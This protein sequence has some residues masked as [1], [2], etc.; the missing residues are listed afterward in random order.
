VDLLPTAHAIKAAGVSRAT[1]Q[2]WLKEGRVKNA[3]KLFLGKDGRAVR[4]WSRAQ[5]AELKG[6]RQK[7]PKVP[8]K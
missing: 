4:L 7:A 5:I 8:K 2:R 1:L 6:L 3:P